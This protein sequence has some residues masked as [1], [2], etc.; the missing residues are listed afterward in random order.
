[1]KKTGFEFTIYI[2][3]ISG[4][5]GGISLI[6]L[7]MVIYELA[8]RFTDTLWLMLCLKPKGNKYLTFALIAVPY[9]AMN[10]VSAYKNFENPLL[11]VASYLFLIVASFI[12]FENKATEKIV[13][14]VIEVLIDTV[15]T[16]VY[17]SLANFVDITRAFEEDM[18]G[19]LLLFAVKTLLCSIAVIFWRRKIGKANISFKYTNTFLLLPVSQI[20]ICYA[21]QSFL[22]PGIWE[23]DNEIFTREGSLIILNV[24]IVLTVIAD[25][26][27]F[28]TYDKISKNEKMERELKERDYREH[29][30]MEHYKSLEEN[31]I[32]MRKLRHDFA[33]AIEVANCMAESSSENAKKTAQKMLGNMEEELRNIHIERYCRNELVNSILSEKAKSCR[34]A[35][36]E[37][38][39]RAVV[40]DDT[41]I[42]EFDMC[43]ALTNIIDNSIN[44]AAQSDD[45]KEIYISVSLDEGNF[46]VVSENASVPHIEKNDGSEHGYGLKILNDTAE[47]YNGSFTVED[48][49][50]TFRATLI[51]PGRGCRI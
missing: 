5:Y 6:T 40:P 9:F 39:F 51:L 48:D 20:V 16:L 10:L 47:K 45:D 43:R 3:D 38:T 28:L 2:T 32:Q 26:M 41:G 42:E 12:L 49:K 11:T 14:P 34:A 33:N 37:Y 27:V 22:D 4:L 23:S 29:I 30:M 24:A 25:I 21:F 44:A 31:A 1:M 15:I 36:V 46:T 35:G 7:F 8:M 13:A 50:K 19:L 18:V 17:F